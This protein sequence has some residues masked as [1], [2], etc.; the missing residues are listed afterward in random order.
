M[1][2]PA[3]SG[4]AVNR[5]RH[6]NPVGDRKETAV[7]HLSAED[8][9]FLHLETVNQLTQVMLVDICDPSTAR[10]DKVRFKDII[11]HVGKQLDASPIPLDIST[12]RRI[13]AN[14]SFFR[15]C[16]RDAFQELL[17]VAHNAPAE[18]PHTQTAGKGPR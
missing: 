12:D 9:Q 13:M 8:A 2:L 18:S 17:E 3:C 7:Q 15:E 10:G 5:R 6:R 4:V 16:L 11:A 1:R 14:V